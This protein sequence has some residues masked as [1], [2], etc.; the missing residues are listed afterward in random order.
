MASTFLNFIFLPFTSKIL[1]MNF[2]NRFL[3]CVLNYHDANFLPSKLNLYFSDFFLR[4]NL[5]E[6]TSNSV[7]WQR[8]GIRLDHPGNTDHPVLS[9][10]LLGAPLTEISPEKMAGKSRVSVLEFE[11]S[12]L[13][14]PLFL[15]LL[16]IAGSTL[17]SWI[18]R[19]VGLCAVFYTFLLTFH[20]EAV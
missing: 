3:V 5:G 6:M 16:L 18:L 7:A 17:V 20:W 10:E 19:C 15:S 9:N 1:F 8:A 12:L 4:G 11:C 14:L 2:S 13:W